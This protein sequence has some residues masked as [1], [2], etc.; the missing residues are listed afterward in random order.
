MNKQMYKMFHCMKKVISYIS[1]IW[2]LLL[3]FNV[4]AQEEWGKVNWIFNYY[5]GKDS[6]L[7]KNRPVFLQFSEVPG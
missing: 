1:L 7:A 3:F 6:A 5:T 4:A 2:I